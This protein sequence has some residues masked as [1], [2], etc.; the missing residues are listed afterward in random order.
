[1]IAAN[2]SIEP[3]AID[4]KN[5]VAMKYRFSF[6]QIRKKT[7]SKES[8]KHTKN[9]IKFVVENSVMLTLSIANNVDT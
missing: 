1:M 5:L 4:T 2:K 7:R 9:I 6:Q 8:S 3:I